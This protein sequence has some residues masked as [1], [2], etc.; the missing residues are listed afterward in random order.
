MFLSKKY[1]K[2]RVRKLSLVIRKF[3][4]R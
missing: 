1:K 2:L 3:R 4:I